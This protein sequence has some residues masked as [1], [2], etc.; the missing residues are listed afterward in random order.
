MCCVVGYIGH[1]I[2][3]ANIATYLKKQGYR[4]LFVTSQYS[5]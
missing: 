5:K 1:F 3:M 4:I 2:P